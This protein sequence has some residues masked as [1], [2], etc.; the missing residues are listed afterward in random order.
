[1]KAQAEA[2]RGESADVEPNAK[3]N[4]PRTRKLR[5][6]KTVLLEAREKFPGVNWVRANGKA[7]LKGNGM[8]KRAIDLRTLCDGLL[9]YS[10]P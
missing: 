7:R 4:D 6:Y 8:P 3:R 10:R 2:A 9:A 5:L 1:M